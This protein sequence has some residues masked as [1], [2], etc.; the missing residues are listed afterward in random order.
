M[1]DQVDQPFDTIAIAI[2]VA[3]ASKKRAAHTSYDTLVFEIDVDGTYHAAI[4]L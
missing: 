1:T 4:C 2:L 3:R